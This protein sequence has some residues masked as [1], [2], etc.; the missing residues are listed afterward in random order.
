MP[1]RTRGSPTAPSRTASIE[2][3]RSSSL[4]REDLAGAQVPFG[5]EVELDQLD[6]E[7]IRRDRLEHLEGLA[8]DLGARPVAPDHADGVR[9]GHGVTSPSLS[10][11]P[12]DI[13][14]ARLTAAR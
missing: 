8:D 1:D 6:V 9:G 10:L 12:F 4:V 13:S 14:I 7:A 3:S 11:V 5:A 2:R